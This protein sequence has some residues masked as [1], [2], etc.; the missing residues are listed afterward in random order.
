M[1]EAALIL[2]ICLALQ[3]ARARADGMDALV[4]IA[5][6]EPVT[7]AAM[8][9]ARDIPPPT[10]R[11][12]DVSKALGAAELPGTAQIEKLQRQFEQAV[13][14]FYAG[15]D[16]LADEGLAAFIAALEAEP[17]SFFAEP[18]LRQ[19]LFS[20]L[21]HRAEVAFGNR[22]DAA[23]Q[24]FVAQAASR[25]SGV[26]PQARDFPPWLR[27][28]HRT[29]AESNPALPQASFQVDA[30]CEVFLDGAA[31]GRGPSFSASLVPGRHAARARCGERLGPV[32]VFDLQDKSIEVG[33]LGL[34]HG[35]L[36]LFGELPWLESNAT[37]EDLLLDAIQI[38]RAAGLA[39]LAVVLSQE[40]LVVWLDVASGAKVRFVSFAQAAELAEEP[41]RAFLPLLPPPLPATRPWFRD[42]VAATFLVVGIAAFTTGMVLARVYGRPSEVEPYAWALLS[43]GVG[44]AVTGIA[45]YIVPNPDSEPRLATAGVTLCASF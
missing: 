20:A 36:S 25:F 42:G 39:R 26:V 9:A 34:H 43:G 18:T 5:G 38:G 19:A 15:R 22:D 27:E 30:K 32:K 37:S 44:S 8:K 14:H 3:P 45:L 7:V 2:G 23:V 1:R 21:L 4:L 35:E 41:A 24:R 11:A 33:L 40:E 29:Q 28:R 12:I 13:D 31:V 6:P 17:A 16:G 10:M